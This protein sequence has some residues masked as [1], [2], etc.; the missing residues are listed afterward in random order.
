MILYHHPQEMYCT[1][2]KPWSGYMVLLK[3]NFFAIIFFIFSIK[4][5]EG[6][7]QFQRIN[8]KFMRFYK[9]IFIRENIFP[10]DE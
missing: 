10:L 9:T 7:Y 3:L 2:R 6:D 5:F 8:N 4:E 1:V